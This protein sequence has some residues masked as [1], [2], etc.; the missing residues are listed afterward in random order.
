GRGHAGE[1]RENLLP[2]GDPG[3]RGLPAAPP[4]GAHSRAGRNGA[5]GRRPLRDEGRCPRA[6][7][8]SCSSLIP[9]YGSKCFANPAV[10]S[11]NYSLSRMRLLTC[12]PVIQEVLQGFLDERAYRLARNSVFAFPII[13]SPLKSEVFEEAAQLYRAA[14][15]AGL[16]IRSGVDCLIAVCALRHGLTVLH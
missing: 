3:H 8:A 2:G 13:E 1:R 12:L 9:L 14:R 11:W 16:T 10:S 7:G 15:R 5:M 6:K 4:R